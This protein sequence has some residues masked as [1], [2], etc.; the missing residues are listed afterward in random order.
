MA[1]ERFV[2]V[3]ERIAEIAKETD[4]PEKYDSYFKKTAEFLLAVADI[5]KR[6]EA[7]SLVNRSLEECQRDNIVM[8][9]DVLP[10]NYVKSFTNPAYAVDVLGEDYG[11][12]LSALAVM[13][14]Q[15]IRDAFEGKKLN[16][17]IYA[18]LFVEIYN[19]FESEEGINKT[20]V[21]QSIYWFHHDYSE[22]FTS[23]M[24]RQMVS[25]KEDFLKDIVMNSDLNDLT[26][27]YLSGDYVG[28][29]ELGV[30]AFMNTLSE[31]EVQA[32]AD[33]Y[34]EGYRI[35]FEYMGVDLGKKRTAQII[36]PLGFER[37]VRAAIGNFEKMGYRS[38]SDC[39]NKG[40]T[41]LKTA[42]SKTFATPEGVAKAVEIAKE[43]GIEGIVVIGGD[44]SFRGARALSDA[45]LPTVG[46]PGT[47]D[48]DIACTDYT[49]GFDTA[50]N[51]ACECI[52]KLKDKCSGKLNGPVGS[53]FSFTTS[54]VLSDM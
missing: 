23:E 9:C 25:E 35:G 4:V 49:I 28:E 48:N 33:T 40:G 51:T 44:G 27:L 19:H 43:K 3:M 5:L 53:R 42:R 32:M 54:V 29:N 38:V 50:L 26:Y 21:E 20:S 24:I 14:R 39:L 36:Y 37:M 12:I 17:T 45:G 47:I 2:L 46:I 13:V 31:E 16:V 30:A 6:K 52:D 11:Q 10:E 34:T 7:G 18:E 1:E 15:S 8:Y 22:I 41:I